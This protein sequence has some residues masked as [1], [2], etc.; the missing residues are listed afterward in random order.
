MAQSSKK[1]DYFLSPKHWTSI[2]SAGKLPTTPDRLASGL[3]QLAEALF[4]RSADGENW[5][6]EARTYWRLA[7]LRDP[8]MADAW[9]GLIAVELSKNESQI[10]ALSEALATTAERIG[11]EQNHYQRHCRI[12]Y[13]IL[14]SCTFDVKT[15]DDARLYATSRLLLSGDSA[16]ASKW[17]DRCQDT[18]RIAASRAAIALHRTDYQQ[19]LDICRRLALGRDDRLRLDGMIGAS[20]ALTSLGRANE[21]EMLLQQVLGEAKAPNCRRAA[22]YTLA[23]VYRVQQDSRREQ[24]ELELLEKES[25]LFADVTS[26]LTELRE[27]DPEIAWL[28]ITRRLA[29]PLADDPNIPDNQS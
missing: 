13:S 25:P 21:A 4:R 24:A 26:R 29:G 12:T 8:G 17:L 3:W 19:A 20:I 15:P 10:L 9:I 23:K 16:R 18:P 11:E 5:L 14:F 28:D 6:D 22:R 27:R 1:G 7:T 2:Q